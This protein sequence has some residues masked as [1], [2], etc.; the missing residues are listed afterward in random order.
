MKIGTD[1]FAMTADSINRMNEMLKTINDAHLSLQN[2][3]MKADVTAKVEGLGENIDV[4][5]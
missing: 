3:M 2:K 4:E 1:N 5:A